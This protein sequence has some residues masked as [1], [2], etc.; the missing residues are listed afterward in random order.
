MSL[1][2]GRQLKSYL[3]GEK[4]GDK[5]LICLANEA[6]ET[7][8]TV[9][10]YRTALG[11][12]LLRLKWDL[13]PAAWIARGRIK[14]WHNRYSGQSAII[15]CNGPSLNKVN[16]KDLSQSGVFTFGLN[17][18]NLLFDKTDFRPA[19]I[20]AVN[21]DV[22][23][24]NAEFYN[25]TDLP[26]FLDT[27]GSKYVK[28]RKNIH[29]LHAA[30]ETMRFARDCSVS[31]NQGHTVTY[32]AMQLAFHMGFS[33]VGLVGC[34]HS[35]AVQ[36]PANKTIIAEGDD[37][38]HFDPHYF[39]GGN[40]WRM[41]DLN[42]SELYYAIAKDIYARYNRELVNCTAGG[43]LEL[44]DRITLDKFLKAN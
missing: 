33:K 42:R 11:L 40:K 12:V 20:V 6:G 8:A 34:D 17:K 36:G 31:I 1:R 14:Q 18:I 44:L 16:F 13:I 32:V 19:V 35:Y 7:R 26:L 38:D 21:P 15:M 10:P 4:M 24:Q 39:S 2:I 22:I 41:A 28:M 27:N 29:Y 43:K 25:Q 3:K 5:K 30:V 37:L 23:E 9:N